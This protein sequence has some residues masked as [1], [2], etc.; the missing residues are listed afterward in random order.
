MMPG[1]AFSPGCAVED[2]GISSGLGYMA[3][4]SGGSHDN[5][6]SSVQAWISRWHPLE[7]ILGM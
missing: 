2:L 6:G 5:T 1:R 4:S 7:Y 3:G